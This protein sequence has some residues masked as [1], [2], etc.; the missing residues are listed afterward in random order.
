MKKVSMFVGIVELAEDD[1]GS[2]TIR[3]HGHGPD[4]HQLSEQDTVSMEAALM[5]LAPQY[6]AL[7]LEV[8]KILLAAGFA[9]A[10]IT[11]GDGGSNKPGK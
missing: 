7:G 6:D 10:G 9:K 1:D 11:P 4:Y 3:Y 2:T 5:P 8:E